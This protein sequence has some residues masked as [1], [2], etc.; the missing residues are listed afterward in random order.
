[1]NK[2]N[3]I[4]AKFY[5]KEAVNKVRCVLCPHRCFLPNNRTG[6]CLARKNIDGVLYTM[7]YGEVTSY[8][9]DPIEKK[10]L[11]HF[12]PGSEIFSIGT[13]GCNFKCTFCQNWTIS[14]QKVSAEHFDKEGIVEMAK[15]ENSIGIAY[16]YNE[17]TIWYEFVYDTAKL[18]KENGLKNVLVTNGFISEEPLKEILPLI[19]AMNIDLK[20]GSESFYRELCAGQ[21]PPVMRTIK[22]AFEAGCHIELTTLI[23]PTLNDR[24]EELEE[25]VNWVASISE[26]IPLHF[27]RYFPQYKMDLDPTPIETLL[28]AYE[29]GKKK[30]KNVYLGNVASE[31]GGAN[32]YCPKCKKELIHREFYDIKVTGLN[33]NTCKY[34]GEKIYGQF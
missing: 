9:M 30:L 32:T 1:L 33:K 15:A 17:P 21:L 7:N 22:I 28:N 6:I 27:S 19:D 11:Y 20:A 8:A 31:V 3:L 29:I 18:A 13:W 4:E 12:Y 2:E 23:I 25:I 26:D 24:K 16:T 34:C 5:K 10:P 14:Q